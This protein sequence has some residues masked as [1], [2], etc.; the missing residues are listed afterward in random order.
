MWFKHLTTFTSEFKIY[1]INTNPNM[2]SVK[3][4]GFRNAK[5][6]LNQFLSI[7]NSSQKDLYIY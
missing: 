6:F 5:I 4:L 3:I 7:S 2:D 1:S